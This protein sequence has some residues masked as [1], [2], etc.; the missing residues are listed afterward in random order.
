MA[1]PQNAPHMWQTPLV[2]AFCGGKGLVGVARGVH[3]LQMVR[4]SVG[5]VK[6]GDLGVV[7]NPNWI[8]K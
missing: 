3:G 8:A 4:G 2:Q 1:S 6:I 5:L 7:L